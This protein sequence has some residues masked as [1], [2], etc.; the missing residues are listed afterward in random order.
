MRGREKRSSRRSNVNLQR[1]AALLQPGPGEFI[2]RRRVGS[3]CAGRSRAATRNCSTTRSSRKNRCD[4]YKTNADTLA[5][6][7]MADRAA[8]DSS[9]AQMASDNAAIDNA[10]VQ[11]SYTAIPSPIEG[12]TGNLMVKRGNVVSANSIAVDPDHAG[13]ADLR[14]VRGAGSDGLNDV[15]KYMANG[16]SCRS[17]RPRR[18]GCSRSTAAY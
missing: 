2:A 9:K 5:Q 15:K 7:V 14:D 6:S 18:M 3:I 11:L 8:I 1:D 13:G 10:K 17:R 12:R 16:Q 4:Q